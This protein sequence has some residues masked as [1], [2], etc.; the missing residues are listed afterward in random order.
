VA[1][2]TPLRTLRRPRFLTQEDL[3]DRCRLSRTTIRRL[4]AGAVRPRMHTVTALA[5]G[6]H[7]DA[8]ELVPDPAQFWAEEKAP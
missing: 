2:G 6:L 4:E 5:A 3:P 7:V 1:F 8:G